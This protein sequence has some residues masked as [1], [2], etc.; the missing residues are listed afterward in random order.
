MVKLQIRPDH[1]EKE[2][3]I[4]V[5]LEEKKKGYITLCVGNGDNEIGVA[6]LSPSGGL[7]PYNLDNDK[8]AILTN[9]GFNIRNRYIN[10]KI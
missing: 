6:F 8:V 7:F 9:W 3:P 1:T 2:T 10:T 5:W 4:N